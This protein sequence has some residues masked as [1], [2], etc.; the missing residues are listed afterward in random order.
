VL[1]NQAFDKF[2]Y[3]VNTGNNNSAEIA[4]LFFSVPTVVNN[5]D[6]SKTITYQ[7]QVPGQG[8][9]AHQ[10]TIRPND[11]L[12]DWG[13]QMA[14]ADK[15]LSQGNFNLIWQQQP[16][17][18]ETD[19]KYERTQTTVNY[20]EDNEFDYVQTKSA[21]ALEKPV[22]W[23]SVSQQ[24]FNTTLIAVKERFSSGDIKFIK[25]AEDTTTKIAEVTTTLHSKVPLGA[26]AS[27]P[28]QLY[29]G[30]NDYNILRKHKNEIPEMDK[31]VNLGRDM[32]AFVRP[33]NKFIVMPVFGFFKSFVGSLGI[34]IL[35]LTLFIRLLT[36]PLVFERCE[37]E[38]ITSGN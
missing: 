23:V 7:V 8:T 16:S 34:A 33:I 14:G 19:V 31:I 25:N 2:S 27:I 35:L 11:Y 4:D 24:F 12:I 10:F 13:V 28:L 38:S 15:M 22:Q 32:Y 20:Y 9:I 30:P 17:Q 1:N 6:K 18:H 29:F 36:S 26:T 37:N 5:A 3:R 21:K